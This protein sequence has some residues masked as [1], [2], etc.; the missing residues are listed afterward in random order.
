MLED[1]DNLQLVRCAKKE[2]GIQDG[3]TEKVTLE[4]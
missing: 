1:K 4:K 2:S 3:S